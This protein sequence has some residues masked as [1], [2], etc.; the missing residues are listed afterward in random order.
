MWVP[1]A[2]SWPTWDVDLFIPFPKLMPY[3]SI[4]TGPPP[5]WGI[6]VWSGKMFI[7]VELR[8]NLI[9]SVH[10]LLF[11]FIF[12]YA[13]LTWQCEQE[14]SNSVCPSA[15]WFLTPEIT[16]ASL[17]SFTFFSESILIIG[18]GIIALSSPIR[19]NR[20][21]APVPQQLLFPSKKQN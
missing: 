9:E 3:L 19:T 12:F 1:T 13:R 18:D 15:K 4:F 5:G 20:Q 14:S 2:S 10:I 7:V 21:I 11:V 16:T 6:W 8:R 17:N